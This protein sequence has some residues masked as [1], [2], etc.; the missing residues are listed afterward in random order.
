MG[1]IT[2]TTICGIDDV[3]LFGIVLH[4]LHV[5]ISVKI[6]LEENKNKKTKLQSK[7]VKKRN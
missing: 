2:F 1:H 5:S 7:I 3:I 4:S 6:N